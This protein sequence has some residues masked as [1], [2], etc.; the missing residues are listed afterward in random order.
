MINDSMFAYPR[1]AAPAEIVTS[2]LAFRTSHP[3]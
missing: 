1:K 2:A 3:A